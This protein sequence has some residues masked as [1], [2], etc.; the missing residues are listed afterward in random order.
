MALTN[1]P[2]TCTVLRCWKIQLKLWY[3][4]FGISD[5]WSKNKVPLVLLQFMASTYFY[6]PSAMEWPEIHVLYS[7]C[8]HGRQEGQMLSGHHRSAPRSQQNWAL[9]PPHL[10]GWTT[11]TLTR[12]KERFSG[13]MVLVGPQSLPDCAINFTPVPGFSECLVQAGERELCRSDCHSLPPRPVWNGFP[14]AVMETVPG[15][16]EEGICVAFSC[17]QVWGGESPHFTQS[18]FPLGE[19]ISDL[20]WGGRGEEQYGSKPQPRKT[21]SGN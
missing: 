16:T 5:L 14:V 1:N 7:Q 15:V 6:F 20:R 4:G 17:C 21:M 8:A 9:H 11:A 12:H 13:C 18:K 10:M 2:N 3:H 19:C